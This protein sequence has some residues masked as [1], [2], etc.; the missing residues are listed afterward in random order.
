M[1]GHPLER[2]ARSACCRSAL[3]YGGIG[4]AA[5]VML[6]AAEVRAAGHFSEVPPPSAATP[7]DA[8]TPAAPATPATPAQADPLTQRGWR[9]RAEID[10][11]YQQLRATKAL[12]NRIDQPNDVTPVVAKYIPVGTTFDDAAAPVCESLA[13][14]ISGTAGPGVTPGGT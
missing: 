14:S 4:M 8:A 12:S 11:N 10:A 13:L 2:P 3:L 9:L 7:A 6:S 1:P 5:I